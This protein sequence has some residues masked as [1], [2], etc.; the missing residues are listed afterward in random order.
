MNPLCFETYLRI[1]S[2]SDYDNNMYTQLLLSILDL[3]PILSGETPAES[4]RHIRT[5]AQASEKLGY[6]RYWVAEHHNM[7]GIGSSSP[8]VLIGHIAEVTQSI[9][10]GSGGI[11]LPNHSSFH[12]AEVFRTLEALY[13]GR[14][15]LG[16]GRAPGSGSRA[17]HA[18]RG[19]RGFSA[20]DFP[21]QLEDLIGYFQDGVTGLY[22]VPKVSMPEIWML[23]SSD[24]GA[25][26]AA[27][28]GLPYAFA[29]HFSHLP[30]IDIIKLYQHTFVPSEFLSRPKAMMGVHIICAQTDEEARGLAMSSDLSFSLF[31]QTGRSIPLPTV[32]EARAYPYTSSDW[33]Q[34]RA[35]SMPKFVGSPATIKKLLHP[36]LEAGID[37][38]MILSMIHDQSARIKSYELIADVLK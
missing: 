24:F 29:Q 10:V 17:A 5:L 26:L 7:E 19:S 33:E 30:A 35:G 15:D 16:L 13:P 36:Y 21:Q 38:L 23:G 31:V 20:E 3:C 12:V 34:V 1:L 27:K 28:R 4:F 14:I 37:E 25:R 9:R 11:M 6:H 18:L 2:G 8:E 22:A 32:A